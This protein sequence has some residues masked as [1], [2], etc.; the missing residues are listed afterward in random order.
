VVTKNANN[1]KGKGG[2]SAKGKAAPKVPSK[3]TGSPSGS[4]IRMDLRAQQ[5]AARTQGKTP[6][7]APKRTAGGA[8]RAAQETATI[9]AGPALKGSPSSS[10]V[11]GG[12]AKKPSTKPA[13]KPATAKSKKG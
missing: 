2:T 6:S 3:A 11:G 8:T 1:A 10:V 5:Q 9:V 12:V 7:P 13:A 4:G